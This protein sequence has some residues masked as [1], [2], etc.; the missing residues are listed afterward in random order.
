MEKK[1]TSLFEFQKFAHN[2][3]LDQ[4]LEEAENRYGQALSD[5]DLEQVSAA[6]DPSRY[7][8]PHLLEE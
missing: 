8:S 6:G 7:K 1:L 5:D 2:P 4:M 3:R